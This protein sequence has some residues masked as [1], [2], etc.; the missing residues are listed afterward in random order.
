MVIASRIRR[1]LVLAAV[2]GCLL[3]AAIVLSFLVRFEGEIGAREY[4]SLVRSITLMVPV[5]LIVL[6]IADWYRRSVRG[7][8]THDLWRLVVAVTCGSL[9]AWL[10]TAAIETSPGTFMPAPG[11][12]S[13][14]FADKREPA[15]G[16]VLAQAVDEAGVGLQLV[17]THD[18]ARSIET[19]APANIPRSIWVAEWFFAI[20]LLG[21]LQ[22][23]IYEIHKYMQ[24][25]AA[26][27]ASRVLVVGTCPSSDA[28]VRALQSLQIGRA[29]V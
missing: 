9:I 25:R 4:A 11:A 6:F 21:G 23:A 15:T 27:S 29:H 13:I 16:I 22:V 10:G 20:C 7:L 28:V 1:G 18:H 24:R 2:N 8:S 5:Q 17:P 3:V 26:G 12:R 14:E 19:S